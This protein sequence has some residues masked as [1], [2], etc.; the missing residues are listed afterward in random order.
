M[1]QARRSKG[2]LCE[3]FAR[4]PRPAAG[5]VTHPILGEVPCC[6]EC[7]LHLDLDLKTP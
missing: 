5:T 6:R 1:K 3:W 2:G 4:C 7:A